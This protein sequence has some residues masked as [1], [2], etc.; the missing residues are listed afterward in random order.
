MKPVMK[1]QLV[2]TDLD[3]TLVIKHQDVTPRASQAIKLL[4]KHGCY[5]GIAS[6]RP[7]CQI[8]PQLE[9]WD[10]TPDVI[11]GFNGCQ[12]YD[13]ITK[14]TYNYFPMKGEWIKEV[15]EL[16][17]D[18]DFNPNI[19]TDDGI[20]YFGKSPTDMFK[21]A[22]EEPIK[23]PDGSYT[24]G[25]FWKYRIVDDWNFFFQD[26]AKIMLRCTEDECKRMEE[27]L[28]THP[29]TN[30]KGFKTGP[31]LIEFAN[32]HVSKGYAL[33]KFCEFENLDISKTIGMGDTSNDNE[34][35]KT[36]GTG[37]CMANGSD[38]TKAIA[39]DITAKPCDDDGWADYIEQAVL[40]PNGWNK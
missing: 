30:Y 31:E 7:L 6:G 15:F 13:G 38:D 22:G 12:L 34:L 23:Q 18:F 24:L 27:F 2:I 35:L 3:A 39:D 33:E 40:I 1:P 16:M 29:T 17:K 21:F 19:V 20:N 11:L 37:V 36:A 4:Q 10:I 8:I 25:K 14:K 26:N 32:A 28:S 9:E 5:F